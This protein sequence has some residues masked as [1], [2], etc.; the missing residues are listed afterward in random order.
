V[1]YISYYIINE[2]VIFSGSE[3]MVYRRCHQTV[4]RMTL[5]HHHINNTYH[6]MQGPEILH[7]N[8]Y[9]KNKQSSLM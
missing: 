4:S 2:K 8:I 1:L 6:L 9:L 7:D 5:F 3:M